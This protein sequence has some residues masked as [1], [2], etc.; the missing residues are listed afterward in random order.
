MKKIVT[1]IF[2]LVL[3]LSLITAPVTAKELSQTI[4]T[5]PDLAPVGAAGLTDKFKA[6]ES[7]Q[8]ISL[9]K[10]SIYIVLFEGDSLVVR[11]G[12]AL[13][14]DSK[15]PPNRITCRNWQLNVRAY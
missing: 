8:V 6:E 11:S 1:K 15:A 3:L 13:N 10:E 14:L 12:G 9:D 4:K 7:V 2:S 5:N